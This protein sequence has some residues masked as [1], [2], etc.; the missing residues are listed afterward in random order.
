MV[1]TSN[2]MVNWMANRQGQSLVTMVLFLGVLVG[3]TAATIDVGRIQYTKNALQTSLSASALAGA[4]Y[5]ADQ[6]NSS[7]QSDPSLVSS[8]TTYCAS[9][10]SGGSNQAALQSAVNAVFNDNQGSHAPAVTAT[11]T[12]VTSNGAFQAC[13]VTTSSRQSLPLLFGA[14]VGVPKSQIS[15]VAHGEAYAPNATLESSTRLGLPSQ[16]NPV[17]SSSGTPTYQSWFG[18][19]TFLFNPNAY[20]QLA[21]GYW[22]GVYANNSSGSS[23]V[24]GPA[25]AESGKTVWPTSKGISVGDVLSFPVFSSPVFASNGTVKGVT[26]DGFISFKVTATHVTPCAGSGGRSRSTRSCF[27]AVPVVNP[28]VMSLNDGVAPASN[29]PW[30]ESLIP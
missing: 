23:Y 7:M 12:A 17:Y 16:G 5:I 15:Q 29:T 2:K 14:A 9:Y 24:T 26:V 28:T 20:K 22:A 25:S 11:A 3:A 27:D 4:K 13:E 10:A 19:G 1:M 6:Y 30:T 21:N 18:D 8:P